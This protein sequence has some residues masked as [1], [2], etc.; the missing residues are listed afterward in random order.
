ML[1]PLQIDDNEVTGVTLCGDGSMVIAVVAVFVHVP[2]LTVYN[3]VPVPAVEPVRAP[4][5]PKLAEPV[6]GFTDQVPP[7]V[8]SVNVVDAPT[9]T[10]DAPPPMAATVGIEFTY[11]DVLPL[12][13]HPPTGFV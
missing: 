8:A 12:V 2:L 11:T 10:V 7:P 1:L 4:P 9:H 6:P 5:D 3:T 13:E